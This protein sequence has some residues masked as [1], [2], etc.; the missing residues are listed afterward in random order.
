[1]KTSRKVKEICPTS[2]QEWINRG[3]LMVDVREKDEV[4]E[5]GYAVPNIVNIPLS[6]F[7]ERFKE[8]PQDREVVMVCSGGSRSLRTAHYLLSHGY[9]HSKV[10]NMK[11]GLVRWVQKGFPTHGNPAVLNELVSECCSSQDCG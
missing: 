3:A 6:E 8:V 10:V 7:E 5:L 9:D 1:M 2:T 4:D 11:H